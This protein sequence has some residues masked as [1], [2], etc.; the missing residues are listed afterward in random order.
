MTLHFSGSDPSD[1]Q[2]ASLNEAN[3]A[4]LIAALEDSNDGE[5][6]ALNNFISELM[7]Y[8]GITDDG[9]TQPGH[10]DDCGEVALELSDRDLCPACEKQTG[11]VQC[12]NCDEYV[13]PDEMNHWPNLVE[14]VSMCNSCEHNARR[15]GWEPGQ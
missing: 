3:N 15:S 14:P 11:E 10:C 8:A 5:I 13:D 9:E 1:E 2:R 6:A 4:T 12:P 7:S